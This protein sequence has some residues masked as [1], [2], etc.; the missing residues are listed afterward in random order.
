MDHGHPRVTIVTG[1]ASGMGR[2]L[3][4]RLAARG[5]SVV[6]A[7]LD[8]DALGWTS[9][10]PTVAPITVDVA[11]EEGNAA[12]VDLACSR[13]GRLDGVALNAGVHAV[14]AIDAM[15]LAD[16][17]R[18]IAVNLRGVVL[19]MRA[20]IPVLKAA[21]GGA[22][23]VTSS[24]GGLAGSRTGWG[25][26]ATK[27]AVVNLVKSVA[28]EVGPEAVRVNAVCPGPTRDTT[29]FDRLDEREPDAYARWTG[30]I[31]LRR[32]A[33]PGEI[34]A[35]MDFLLSPDAS[36]VTGAAIPVDGGLTA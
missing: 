29:M 19:G 23:V 30:R 17:D 36:F 11:T 31:P 34:A 3:C 32:W 14:G 1:A 6:A 21:G 16:L 33:A 35:V 25:Y 15:P 10:H 22:I 28:L 20:T 2:A 12:M 27:A 18:M 24:T 5:E 26:G 8:G 4:E 9:S 7:D 13:F